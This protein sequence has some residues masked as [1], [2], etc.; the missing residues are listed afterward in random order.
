M[1]HN[2]SLPTPPLGSPW[3]GAEH[4]RCHSGG[5]ELAANGL[6]ATATLVSSLCPLINSLI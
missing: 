2:T 5:N 1:Q 6:S 4:D 3:S